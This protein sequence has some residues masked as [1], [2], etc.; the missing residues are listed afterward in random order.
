M[1]AAI[2]TTTIITSMSV[3]PRCALLRVIYSSSHPSFVDLPG[4]HP[5]S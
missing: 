2:M 1:T 3:K 4:S 5:P